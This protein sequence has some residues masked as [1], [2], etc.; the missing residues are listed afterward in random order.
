MAGISQKQF[1]FLKVPLKGAFTGVVIAPLSDHAERLE[2]FESNSNRDGFFYPPQMATYELDLKTHE[3]KKKIE[4]SE[5]S[6]SVF[7]MPASHEISIGNPAGR[8]ESAFADHALIMHLLAFLYGT[9]LQ[10]TEWRFEGR[11]PYKPTNNVLVSEEACIDFLE[12][13][14]CWWRALG[15]EER[16]RFVNIL[17]V[18]TRAR[19]LEWEWDA[20]IH[21]YMVFDALYKL[22]TK[23]NPSRPKAGFHKQRFDVML[24]EYDI[25]A[26]NALIEQIY[27]YRSQLFHEAMWGGS[28]FCYGSKEKEANAFN[29]PRHLGRLNSRIVCKMAGYRNEYASSVWWSFSCF[30]FDKKQ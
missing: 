25:P 18:L 17:Y 16:T 2:W 4:R 27:T 8:V 5:R 14:Y 24:G 9:R 15:N 1:G 28:S 20:F 6:A 29:L 13:V 26:N 22:Y 30:L 11:I 23:L 19:S 12:H 21:Q 3:R 10:L 7:H